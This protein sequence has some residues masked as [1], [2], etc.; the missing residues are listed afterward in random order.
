VVAADRDV[1]RRAGPR[2]LR[3]RHPHPASITS[4]APGYIDAEHELIVGLQTDAPLR[5]A[6][7]PNGGLRMVQQGLAAYG[8]T[9]DP[10]VA[11]ILPGTARPTTTVSSTPTRPTSWPPAVPPH[12]RL[13]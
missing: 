1:P 3:R 8:Y 4:H 10:A 13:A 12:H 9:L 2:H 6:I 5:R 7:M 11:E